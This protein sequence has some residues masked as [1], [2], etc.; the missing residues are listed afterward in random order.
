MKI[1]QIKSTD[2]LILKPVAKVVYKY[3]DNDGIK[4]CMNCDEA[5]FIVK[6]TV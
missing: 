6:N 1:I 5:F 2:L 4:L 3:Y